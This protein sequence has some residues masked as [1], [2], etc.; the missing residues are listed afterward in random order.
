MQATLIYVHDP[1]CS[2]CWAFAP[3]LERLQ[4]E[5]PAVVTTTRLLGGLA[6]DDDAP[7]TAAMRDYLQ[8]TWRRIMATV[9]GTRFNFDFWENTRP[10]RSTWPACRAVIAARGQSGD[11]EARMILAIQQA[12][13]LQARNPSDAAT[14]IALASEIGLDS[15]AFARSLDAPS[16]QAELAAEIQAAR[17]LGADSFP[18]F[19]L[20]I[21]GRTLAIAID[22]RDTAPMCAAI[23]KG[24]E[25]P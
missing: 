3:V 6:P 23:R 2:W 19:R 22:Y 17:Q 15:D 1:M 20:R 21:G 14:L 18:S 11:A 13:Y 5:L 4:R 12:Y 7:M 8:T 9:P 16:T 24:L 25:T 10:R